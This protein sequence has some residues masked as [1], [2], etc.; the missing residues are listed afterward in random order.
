MNKRLIA[1]G[2][3]IWGILLFSGCGVIDYYFLKPSQ[4]TAQE[5][6]ESG[7][8]AMQDKDY[9]QAIDY[10]SELKEKYPFSPFATQAELALAD[11]YYLDE[12]YQAAEEAYKEFESLHPG[13]SSIDY[14]LFQ[15]GKCNFE[16]FKSVDLPQNNIQEAWQYFHRVTESCP[17]SKYATK[18]KEYMHKCRS[19]EIK[20]E[21]FVANFYWRRHKYLAA[22]KRYQ[23]VINNYQDFPEYLSYANKMKELAYFKYQEKS[24]QDTWSK[25]EGGWRTWFD[26]L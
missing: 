24:S 7:N 12:Q 19:Y 26:W 15:I 8:E 2:I 22:W 5:L 25:K 1:Y 16:Q 20:H 17:D 23:Y 4:D 6:M 21:L 3:L 9:D 11:A 18:A 10:F 13:K 14:V